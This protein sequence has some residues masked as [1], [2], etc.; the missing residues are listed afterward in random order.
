MKNSGSGGIQSGRASTPRGLPMVCGEG[1]QQSGVG[2]DVERGVLNSSR[3]G[4]VTDRHTGDLRGNGNGSVTL[5]KFLGREH[6]NGPLAPQDPGFRGV[7]Y[8]KLDTA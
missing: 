1:R 6:T 4:V 3:P 5:Q 7:A 2:C 8:K